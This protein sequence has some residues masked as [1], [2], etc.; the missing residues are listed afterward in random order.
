MINDDRYQEFHELF[1]IRINV[2]YIEIYAH[3]ESDKNMSNVLL[4]IIIVT[5]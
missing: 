2:I 5:K 3:F 4:T 1:R